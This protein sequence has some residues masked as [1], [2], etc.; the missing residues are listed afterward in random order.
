MYF[1]GICPSLGSLSNGQVSF[2]SNP[3]DDGQYPV[4]PIATFTCEEGYYLDTEYNSTTCQN[5]GNWNQPTPM[6]TGNISFKPL[7]SSQRVC[8]K[9]HK[10]KF[11]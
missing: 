11:R 3:D 1:L 2:D 8:P 4:N 7:I 6:C 9:F 5:S 10:Q